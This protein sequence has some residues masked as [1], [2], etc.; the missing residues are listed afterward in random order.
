M[1]ITTRRAIREHAVSEYPKESCGFIV[2]REGVETYVPCVNSNSDPTNHFSIASADYIKHSDESELIA[3]VHS[4][5]DIPPYPSEADRVM[6]EATNVPWH[7]VHVALDDETKLPKADEIFTFTPDG[8]KAPLV[9]RVFVHG[10]LDCFS[11]IK[12]FYK[13]ELNIE[14]PNY[15]REDQWWHKGHDLYRKNYESAGFSVVPTIQKYDVILM[16]IRAP[17]A[18]HAGVYID[19]GILLHHLSGRLSSRELYDGYYQ[20]KTV[21]IF[22]HKDF[23]NGTTND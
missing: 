14:L 15:V 22:R 2:L 16:Q 18:N 11:L 3:V 5:P 21:L 4:H 17:Q 20:E 13:E 6:C 9:G 8:Y 10:V 12:D 23:L 1:N 19:D 7:I